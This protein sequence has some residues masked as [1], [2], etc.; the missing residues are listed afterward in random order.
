MRS[1]MKSSVWCP[2]TGI[3]DVNSC[4]GLL[5]LER[6]IGF[7]LGQVKMREVP[8]VFFQKTKQ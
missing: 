8:R 1:W 4:Q 7:L 5:E 6:E 3:P 2:A